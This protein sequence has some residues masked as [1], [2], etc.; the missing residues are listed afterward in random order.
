MDECPS[1]RPSCP[2]ITPVSLSHAHRCL[3][4]VGGAGQI[5]ALTDLYLY[6]RGGTGWYTIAGITCYRKSRKD[7]IERTKSDLLPLNNSLATQYIVH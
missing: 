2:T 7:E 4:Q 1:Q 3:H 6:E 5:S